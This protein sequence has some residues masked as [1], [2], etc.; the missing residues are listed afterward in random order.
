M[1]LWVFFL[2]SLLFATSFFL[3]ISEKCSYI[4]DCSCTY[5]CIHVGSHPVSNRMH[6]TSADRV[7]M[8]MFPVPDTIQE[9][10]EVPST[11]VPSTQVYCIIH[12]FM[13]CACSG[14]YGSIINTCMRIMYAFT[15]L[16]HY[17]N[18]H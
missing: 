6:Q 15:C 3:S 13:S 16:V 11:Q 2:R 18:A 7:R 9:G 17:E 4:R 5:T 12:E 14:N 10:E 1:G 8:T